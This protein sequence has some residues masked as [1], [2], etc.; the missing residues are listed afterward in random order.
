LET[1]AKIESVPTRA[2]RAAAFWQNSIGKKALMAVTGIILFAFV[3][4][5][6]IGNLQ[7]FAGREKLNAYAEF[8]QHNVGVLWVAR[9]VLLVS[10][11]VHAIAG[12][13]LTMAKRAARPVQYHTWRRIQSTPGSRTM[14]W[15]GVLI[16]VF[17]VYHLL[18]LTVGTAHPSFI[19]G[20]VYANVIEG[21]RQ[22]GASI[23]YI[24]SMVGLGFHLQHGL[25]SMFQS[26]G[27]SHPRYTPG[28]KRFAALAATLIA[29]GNISMPIAILAGLVG[30]E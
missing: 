23:A 6:L 28:F 17:V 3:L 7:V 15:S 22:V 20:D 1:T 27:F 11:A 14:I 4:A 30:G 24:I 21:F 18:H 5:H 10:V 25:Y 8:L 19:R 9:I 13:Q 26:L 29:L 12:I 16:L 2:D